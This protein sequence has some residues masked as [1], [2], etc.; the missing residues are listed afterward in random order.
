[1]R[2]RA[3][4]LNAFVLDI[5]APGMSGDCGPKLRIGFVW[6]MKTRYNLHEEPLAMRYDG[7]PDGG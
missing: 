3:Q 1:M 4:S 6:Y 7:A 5:G 2:S